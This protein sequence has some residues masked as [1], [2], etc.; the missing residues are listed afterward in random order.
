MVDRMDVS[1]IVPSYNS[2]PFIER[3]IASVMMQEGV[4]LEMI[5]IDDAGTD[6]TRPLVRAAQDRYGHDRILLIERGG[7]LGQSTARNAGIDLARGDYIALLDSDDAFEAPDVLV[8]WVAAARAESLDMTIAQ[9]TVIAE[10]GVARSASRNVPHLYDRPVTLAEAPEL[11]NVTSCWQILYDRAFLD[12]NDLR[13]SN[14]LRQREDRL[15]VVQALLKA[16]TIRSIPLSAINHFLLE[17]SSY[18]TINADQVLQY[19]I[20]LEELMDAIEVAR[21]RGTVTPDFERANAISYLL[22]LLGYWRPFLLETWNDDDFAE[23]RAFMLA[24]LR[25]MVAPLRDLWRDVVLQPSNRDGL[26]REAYL[27]ATR[28]ALVAQDMDMLHALITRTPLAASQMANLH[29]H[30]P[31]ETETLCRHMSFQRK[32]ARSMGAPDGLPDVPD[33]PSGRRLSDRVRRVILHVG[34]TK[35]GS[36]SLQQTLERN[37]F[38]LWEQG[39][40]YPLLGANRETGIRRERSNG[41]AELCQFLYDGR[42]GGIEAL[43]DE[44]DDVIAAGYDIHTLVLSSENICSPR[45]WDHGDGYRRIVEALGHDAVEVAAVFRRPDAWLLSGYKELLANPWNGFIG[46]F[47]DHCRLNDSHGLLDHLTVRKI[48]AAPAC[49]TKLHVM[50]HEQLVQNGGIT[51]WFTSVA[52][53]KTETFAAVDSTLNNDSISDTQTA[54]IHLLK[55]GPQ[56][57]REALA[58]GF[59]AIMEGVEARQAPQLLVPG[60]ELAEMYDAQAERIAAFD[61]MFGLAPRSAKLFDAI[62]SE[63]EAD[64]FGITFGMMEWLVQLSQ[65]RNRSWLNRYE[66]KGRYFYSNLGKGMHVDLVDDGVLVTLQLHEN[67]TVN[68]ASIRNISEQKIGSLPTTDPGVTQ[69]HFLLPHDQIHTMYLSGQTHIALTVQ[70]SRRTYNRQFFLEQNTQGTVFLVPPSPTAG[71]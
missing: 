47:R 5:I 41:H 23:T 44:V 24:G 57:P 21:E 48:L 14:R 10:D 34:Y 50:A 13:F 71:G 9:F 61:K 53:I 31:D 32:L 35:T 18:K 52:G 70:T 39:I 45:F 43:C 2:E 46:S 17:G 54:M 3:C 40:H 38:A 11:V 55:C 27:D 19:A 28:L 15:F 8:R 49:V 42:S 1:V 68:E 56:Q 60:E 67:E 59:L 4:T 69:G 7:G 65:D 62:T 16:G 6:A 66:I 64:Q 33:T 12:E 58:K 29:R 37:R 30:F 51:P 36:S 25:R 26:L 63:Q 20:H 22:Q